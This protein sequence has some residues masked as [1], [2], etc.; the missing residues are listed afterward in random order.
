MRHPVV[1]LDETS[2]QTV[3]TRSHARAPRGVRAVARVPRNH[4]ENVTCVMA[5]APTG[6]VEPLVFEG[7]LDGGIF[8]Q[9]MRDRL[10][11]RLAPGTTIVL[12][13]LSVHKNAT[14]RAAVTTAGCT[15]L[16]LPPYSPDFNPIELANAKLKT[17]LRGAAARAFD[18]LVTAIG[19]GLDRITEQDAR[20]FFRHCGYEVSPG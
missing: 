9:W 10:L 17:Y 14:A 20:A 11:P 18:P 4:G 15:L 12:D 13:N 7:P 19:Q 3:M 16:F 1:F 5:I 6:I 8:A 2:T